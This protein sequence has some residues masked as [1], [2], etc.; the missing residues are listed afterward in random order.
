MVENQVGL[1]L[2][3]GPESLLADRAISQVIS[4]YPNAQIS[5]LHSDELEVGVITDNLAPS[6][7]GD[8]RVV[9]IREI[10]DLAAE[11]TEEIASYLENQDENLVLVLWHKGGVKGKGLVD[12]VKKLN[13]QLLS[14]EAI[15]KDSEKSD[16]IRNEF[17]NLNRKIS[18]EAVQALIDSLGSD[19][20]ELGA[21]CSQLASDVELQ[22]IIDAEDVAKYQQGR[23]E[24]TGFDV[25]DAAVEGKTAEAL[26]ALRNALATGT[27]PV[28]IVS[29]LASSFRTL[30]KVSGS[31]KGSNPYELASSLA[32]APW[33]IDKARKQLNGWSENG[34][35]KAV[36]AIAAVDAD[37]KG[38]ASDPKYALERAIMTVTTAKSTR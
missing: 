8:Q 15:K 22:K 10:Q 12:K 28:L 23:V 4:K 6:L 3:Q 26:I 25:A 9:V 19:L 32:L 7:F 33:Q 16:F 24:S 29:A 17:K 20:R 37:I 38:A 11:C 34:L 13:P 2:I 1:V 14:A 5:N 27:D 21:A 35:V 30:A 36:I 31:S 18:T